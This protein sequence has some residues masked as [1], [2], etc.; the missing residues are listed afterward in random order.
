MA[1]L[2]A[3]AVRDGAREVVLDDETVDAL[4]DDGDPAEVTRFGEY[5]FQLCAASVEDL[6]AERVPAGHRAEP[7]VVPARRD[8]EPVRRNAPRPGRRG[9]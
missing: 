5:C 6:A 3:E 1:A 8:R 7:R 4:A 2:V 9:A